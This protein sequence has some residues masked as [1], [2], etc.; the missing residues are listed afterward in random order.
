MT[1]FPWTIFIILLA[2][3]ILGS[4]AVIP[5]SL[6]FNPEVVKKLKSAGSEDSQP[7]K[8]RQMP[9]PVMILLGTLQTIVLFGIA[10]FVG[11]LAA[12][13]VG[14]IVPILQGLVKGLPVMDLVLVML[15][16]AVL[17]GLASGV[18]MLVLEAA[19]F[20]PRIPRRLASLDSHT[21]FWKRVLACF[22]GG[23]CEE[24]LMRLFLMSG[25]VWLLGL[26][27]KAP[28]G[29][30]AVGAFWLANILAALLFGAGHLPATASAV[31][32]TPMIVFRSLLLNGIPGVACGYLYMRYGLEAA[33]LLHFTLDILIHLIAPRFMQARFSSLPSQ[34]AADLA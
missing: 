21:A 22:Y 7:A 2:A 9:L 33:M 34:P 30:P 10:T 15:P 8:G 11:L 19:Y 1:A 5:Y 20:M 23:I 14:L 25:L 27:W 24:I 6:S 29:A 18:V 26:F 31:K 17:L 16:E 13:K 4:A 3:G 28:S 12:G 32:L